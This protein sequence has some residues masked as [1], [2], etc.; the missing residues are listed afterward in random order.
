MDTSIT[1]TRMRRAPVTPEAIAPSAFAHVVLKTSAY[2]RLIDWYVAFLDAHVVFRNDMISFLTYD[3]EHHRVAIVTRPGL[4]P[5]NGDGSVGVHH[6]A[7]TQKDLRSLL[8]NYRRLKALAI[9]PYW[10]IN[11]G[12]TLSMYYRDPDGNQIEFQVET[13]PTKEQLCAYFQSEAFAKNP[14]GVPYD[15]ETLIAEYEAGVPEAEL[16]G[17]TSTG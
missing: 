5:G 12:P 16:F 4:E 11:H 13:L 15:P 7:Y 6:L 14:I 17:Q 1:N 3:D 10:C 2:Q 8:S 9:E